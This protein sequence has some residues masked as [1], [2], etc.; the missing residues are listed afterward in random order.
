MLKDIE[1]PRMSD[2]IIALTPQDSGLPGEVWDCHLIN[3]KREPIRNVLI[4]SR[5]YGTLD[6]E[7]RRSSTLR[8][9]YE[10]IGPEESV[11]LE[12]LPPDLLSLT[13]EF[14]VS[15]QFDGHMYDRRFLFVEGSLEPHNLFPVPVLNKRGVMI[16]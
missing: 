9:F 6:G 8:Y 7:E 13:N 11:L 14:W 15:F 3:L 2:F 12:V 10:A 4:T 5:G 1:Q 16:V